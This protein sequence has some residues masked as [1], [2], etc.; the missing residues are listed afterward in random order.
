MAHSVFSLPVS[1]EQIAA[2]IK[3]MSPAERERLFRLVPE[4][5]YQT[6]GGRVRT[7][8]EVE[9]SVEQLRVA[10]QQALAG[11]ETLSPDTLFLGGLTID[12]YFSLPETDRARLWEVDQPT[13][14]DE[15]EEREVGPDALPA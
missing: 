13:D 10:A 7:Q 8:D 4:I 2:V 11:H 1:V 5:E 6:H 3:Q 9:A 14:W 15:A 12:Q